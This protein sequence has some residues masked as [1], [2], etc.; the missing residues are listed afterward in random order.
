VKAIDLIGMM[1]AHRRSTGMQ[2]T[3]AFVHPADA[4][5]VLDDILDGGVVAS[6]FSMSTCKAIRHSDGRVEGV[7]H[8]D[9]PRY[10]MTVLGVA[11]L[12]DDSHRPG[13]VAFE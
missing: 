8:S 9:D 10:R 1:D 12:A 5:S 6:P 4:Q 7:E 2:P 11:I 13:M 3:V